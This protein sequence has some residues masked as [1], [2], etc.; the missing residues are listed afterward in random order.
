L[1]RCDRAI[2]VAP[3]SAGSHEW[4][5]AESEDLFQN[6]ITNDVA[7]LFHVREVLALPG[8]KKPAEEPA[9]EPEAEDK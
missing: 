7:V 6:G 2:A 8:R 1:S 4:Q 9:P 5:A 3:R